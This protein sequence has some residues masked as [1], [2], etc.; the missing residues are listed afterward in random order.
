[1]NLDF[2]PQ[3]SFEEIRDGRFVL[4][5]VV[6]DDRCFDFF[7]FDFSPAIVS[8]RSSVLGMV[9]GKRK[10]AWTSLEFSVEMVEEKFEKLERVFLLSMRRLK[11]TNEMR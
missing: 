1:M 2:R 11:E 5:D 3:C 6:V 8:S 7:F 9:T 4:D 10:R